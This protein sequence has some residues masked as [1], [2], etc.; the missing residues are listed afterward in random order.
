MLT[1]GVCQFCN[2]CSEILQ[3]DDGASLGEELGI[4]TNLFRYQ[5]LLLG[6][7]RTEQL[8]LAQ[9]FLVAHSTCSILST[10]ELYHGWRYSWCHLC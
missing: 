10:G 5:L 2:S 1:L 7:A 6:A 9:S 4:R 8:V 3:G